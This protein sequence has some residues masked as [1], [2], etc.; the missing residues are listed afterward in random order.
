[1]ADDDFVHEIFGRLQEFEQS[2]KRLQEILNEVGTEVGEA[3]LHIDS[4]GKVFVH[5]ILT[6]KLQEPENAG[7]LDYLKYMQQSGIAKP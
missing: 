6:K 5:P 4:D 7:A 1:M 2:G 3:P